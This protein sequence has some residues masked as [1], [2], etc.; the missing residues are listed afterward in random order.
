M[1]SLGEGATFTQ[2]IKSALRRTNPGAKLT[3]DQTIERSALLDMEALGR[4]YIEGVAPRT[5]DKSRF[6]DKMPLSA[7]TSRGKPSTRSAMMLRST[8]SVPPAI[9][10][11]AAPI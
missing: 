3:R 6:V 4:S 9:L 5:T 7:H 10:N 1:E 8:S 2:V 11:P